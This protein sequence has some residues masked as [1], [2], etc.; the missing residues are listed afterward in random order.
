MTPGARYQA[1]I[2]LID[3]LAQT[4]MPLDRLFANWAKS[5]RY[6]G[7][8]DRRAIKDN[9]FEL[10]R[11]RGHLKSVAGAETG[12]ALMI[13]YLACAV[14][15]DRA[16]LAALFDGQGYNPSEL[17][18]QEIEMFDRASA[19][20]LPDFDPLPDWLDAA[21]WQ[22]APGVTLE[23]ELKAMTRRA[24]VDL[25]IN[26]LKSDREEVLTW[27][28]SDSIPVS[29]PGLHALAL[30]IDEKA[31]DRAFINLRDSQLFRDG[32]IEFQD[33]STQV[34]S[35][36]VDA[37]PKMQVLDLCA[38]AG[39]KTL[40]LAAAMENQGQIF[41]TDISK[42]RLK[43]LRRRAERAGVR[44]LQVDMIKDWQTV[45][46]GPDPDFADRTGAFD[47]VVLDVP[48][49][50]SGVWR[51]S[52]DNKWRLTP[53]SLDGYEQAQ[54]ALLRRG[55]ALVKPGGRLAYITCSLLKS[56]NSDQ[57][58]R[59]I[60]SQPDF[61]PVPLG[62]VWPEV[63]ALNREVL[64][65]TIQP[66]SD[67]SLLLTPESANTDGCFVAILQRRGGRMI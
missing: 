47:R 42:S 62:T 61:E 11:W 35:A 53:K 2:D 50:G 12:R 10:M 18:S 25:R 58:Q 5:H 31:G 39:G 34:A 29:Q 44:N 20:G 27:F 15:M 19:L 26:T 41:A 57:V 40:A 14:Q 22:S 56:E 3:Q 51:R 65:T 23:D 13:A 17:L 28:S 6:A 43:E 48:C 54:A 45:S 16:Q 30:R 9:V 52:P 8:K 46:E 67:G 36:L 49:S 63:A 7:S 1:A 66:Q 24:P 21:L 55:A 64:G 38:G 33:L 60:G 4:Q 59:F 32:K 37:R